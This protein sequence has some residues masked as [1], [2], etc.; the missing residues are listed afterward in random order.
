MANSE[1]ENK[2]RTLDMETEV[3]TLPGPVPLLQKYEGVIGIPLR[4]LSLSETKVLDRTGT[5]WPWSW[6]PEQ[7][8]M[9]MQDWESQVYMAS[10]LLRD[11]ALTPDPMGGGFLYE[12][13]CR[14]EIITAI[15]KIQIMYDKPLG[16]LRPV[17]KGRCSIDL[18]GHPP[19]VRP[20][21]FRINDWEFMGVVNNI[22]TEIRDQLAYMHSRWYE[23]ELR[24]MDASDHLDVDLGALNAPRRA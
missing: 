4:K 3:A 6:S 17:P 1:T 13:F 22:P 18:R 8:A 12:R 16:K 20:T 15:R 5:P 9:F 21:K 14:P 11:L 19:N 7:A 10:P 24:V 23:R 2:R